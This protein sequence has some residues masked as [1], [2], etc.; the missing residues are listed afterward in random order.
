MLR[1]LVSAGHVTELQATL[2][3]KFPVADDVTVEA[4]T[5]GHTDNRP[6]I[7]LLPTILALRDRLQAQFRYADAAARR[8]GRRH[9]DARERGRRVR[10]GRGVRRHRDREPGVR[11][12]RQFGRGA[13]D[14]RRGRA[15]GRHHGPG[16]RHVRDGRE[17]AGAEARH[18]V[19]H[20]GA[21]A[22]R[23][24]PRRT[25]AGR[26]SRRPSASRSRRRC[27][28]P[29]FDEVWNQTRDFLAQRDPAPTARRRR[30]T[31]STR[32]ALVFRWYLGLSSRW[33][34][35]GEA[36]RQV[37]YQVWCGPA[38]GAFNEWAKGSH[39]EAAGEPHGGRRRPEPAVRR[40]RR[41]AARR[42]CG[43]RAWTLPDECFPL[44][45]LTTDEVAQRLRA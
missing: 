6:A 44:A 19:R 1:E 38:M 39:L 29:T 13:Q 34:N 24:V 36:G 18:H 23:P 3:A 4:D 40:V 7:T 26:R 14:A 9:R 27:S 32:M 30:P 11:R 25:R 31:R 35:A 15:G 28:A 22:V 42:R 12:V 33:A 10:D 21:E 5:G 20:A 43:S 8:V 16:R 37:D 41:A 2:A 17:G 45:P